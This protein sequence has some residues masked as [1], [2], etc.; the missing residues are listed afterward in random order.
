MHCNENLFWLNC[1]TRNFYFWTIMI[2][3]ISFCFWVV[4]EIL[5][6]GGNSSVMY[7]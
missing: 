2:I 3:I 5:L 6:V 4:I 1:L 7:V